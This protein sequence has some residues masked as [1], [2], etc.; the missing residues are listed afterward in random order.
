MKVVTVERTIVQTIKVAVLDN[1]S[2]R[3]CVERAAAMPND[4]WTTE[5]SAEYQIQEEIPIG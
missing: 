4:R 2:E 3:Q 5:P 1:E